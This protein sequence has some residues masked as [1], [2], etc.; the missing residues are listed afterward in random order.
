MSSGEVI[1]LYVFILS[2][3]KVCLLQLEKAV[4]KATSDAGESRAKLSH[5]DS[6]AKQAIHKLQHELQ[7]RVGQVCGCSS[8]VA[9][10]WG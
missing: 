5:H 8:R 2:E 4:K 10:S 3:E 7:V 1:G 9:G 6:A